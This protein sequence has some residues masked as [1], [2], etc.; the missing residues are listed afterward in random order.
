MAV[1]I[2]IFIGRYVLD[3]A[4]PLFIGFSICSLLSIF[5]LFYLKRGTS[6]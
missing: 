5:I 2:S 1:P 6:E 3:T 4:L